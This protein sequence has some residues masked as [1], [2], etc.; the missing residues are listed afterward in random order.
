MTQQVWFQWVRLLFDCGKVLS[1]ETA[2]DTLRRLWVTGSG[3]VDPRL[4][5]HGYECFRV[6]FYEFNQG[7][8]NQPFLAQDR[9]GT[10]L[11]ITLSGVGMHAR[12]VSWFDVAKNQ[13][14]TGVR[15]CAKSVFLRNAM[16]QVC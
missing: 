15:S 1:K 2:R 12:R 14:F 9:Q 11:G 13:R 16:V 4:Q 8:P 6:L 5:T 10:H 7:M 3:G